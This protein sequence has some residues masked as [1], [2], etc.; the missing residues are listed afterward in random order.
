[1][2]QLNKLLSFLNLGQNKL[3]KDKAELMLVGSS[4]DKVFLANNGMVIRSLYELRDAFMTMSDNTFTHHANEDRNDFSLWIRDVHCDSDL[5][6]DIL[7]AKDRN[8]AFNIINK[9][10]TYLERIIR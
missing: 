5:A 10:L 8:Q 9:R 1:M 4:D 2:I 6:N 7:K 3:D